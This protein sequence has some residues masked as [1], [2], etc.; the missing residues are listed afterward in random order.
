MIVGLLVLAMAVA[1]IGCGKL[2]K[3]SV[4][5]AAKQ[6]AKRAG[7]QGAKQAAKQWS[8]VAAGQMAKEVGKRLLV[9][10]IAVAAEEVVNAAVTN[11]GELKLE[12]RT[13]DGSTTTVRQQLTEE[14]LQ[15]LKQND[16]RFEV[17]VANGR[18]LSGEVMPQ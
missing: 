12:V 15:H 13:P 1:P 18:R 9:V 3:E 5:L 7:K 11:D 6:G 10:A 2:V 16:G 8:K 4:K 14:Q 17:E